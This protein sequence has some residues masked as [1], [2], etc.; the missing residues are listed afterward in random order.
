M[1]NVHQNVFLENYTH[2]IALILM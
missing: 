1:L 2:L